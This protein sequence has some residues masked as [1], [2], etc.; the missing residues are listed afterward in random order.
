MAT[1]LPGR[2]GDKTMSLATDPRTHPGQLKVL[3]ALGLADLS[4]LTTDLTLDSALDEITAFVRGNEESLEALYH[5]LDY[6]V[7]GEQLI[8]LVK[9]EQLIDG[10]EGNEIRMY[11]TRPAE[12]APCPA[13]A[14]IYFHSGGMIILDT[15]S[16]VHTTWAESLART[17]FVVLAVDFRNAITHPFPAGL[18]DCAAAVRWVDA[19]RAQLGVDRIILQGDSGGGNLALATA[20]RAK[21]EGWLGAIDGV[22][23]A[24]PYISNAYHMPVDWRRREL[25]SLVE[26]DGYLI[27]AGTSAL[28]A[29]MYGAADARDPLAWPYWVEEEELAGLPPHLITVN[30]LDPLRDEGVAYYRKLVRAGVRVSARVN[31]GV[32]HEADMFLRSTLPDLYLESLW[33]IRK[34]ADRLVV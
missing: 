24:S 31:L 20:L 30:E 5:S 21:R 27:S 23:A 29:K 2:L 10:R 16:P 1:N 9:S 19:Q 28:N 6:R 4:Y 8:P 22:C 18:N 17:G 13:P 3:Q 7:A 11:I 15:L 25:P 26:C 12:P 33:A 32:V 34:F 14:L